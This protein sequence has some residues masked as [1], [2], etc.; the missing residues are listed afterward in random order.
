[1]GQLQ[2]WLEGNLCPYFITAPPVLY[3]ILS[4]ADLKRRGF[5][6]VRERVNDQFYLQYL[7]ICIV[8]SAKLRPWP[9]F[10][11]TLL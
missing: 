9:S 8:Q 1:M 7:Y 4:P 2:L 10:I 6:I 11:A 5:S 3:T